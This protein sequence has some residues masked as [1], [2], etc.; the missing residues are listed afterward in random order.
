[1]VNVLVSDQLRKGLVPVSL[2]C[3]GPAL[4]GLCLFG[5]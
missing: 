4:F 3:T 2:V 5:T 1:M